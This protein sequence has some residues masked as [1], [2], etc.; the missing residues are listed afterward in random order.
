MT[1]IVH[2][3][4]IIYKQNGE[5]NVMFNYQVEQQSGTLLIHR[6]EGVRHRGRGGG[7]N[8]YELTQLFDQRRYF[9]HHTHAPPVYTHTHVWDTRIRTS[10]HSSRGRSAH[11]S[12]RHALLP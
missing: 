10:A 12:A 3:D 4:N 8:T 7:L 1:S 11:T 9:I 5:S 6:A 2:K